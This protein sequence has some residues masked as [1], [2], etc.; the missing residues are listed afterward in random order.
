MRASVGSMTRALNIRLVPIANRTAFWCAHDAARLCDL[1]RGQVSELV[2][3]REILCPA[4]EE[5]GKR[6]QCASCLLCGGASVKAKSIAIVAH[7]AGRKHH[8]AAA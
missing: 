4:S 5:A 3:G 1:R 7:G 2:R 6:T 8:A